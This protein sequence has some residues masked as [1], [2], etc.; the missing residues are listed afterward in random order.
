MARL[1]ICGLILTAACA[2]AADDTYTHVLPGARPG[3]VVTLTGLAGGSNPASV[4]T[5]GENGPLSNPTTIDVT[6][7]KTRTYNVT[8][9]DT[10]SVVIT[11]PRQTK[12]SMTCTEEVPYAW[13]LRISWPWCVSYLIQHLTTT[14]TER[15]SESASSRFALIPAQSRFNELH[16]STTD[17]TLLKLGG[18]TVTIPKNGRITLENIAASSAEFQTA[19]GATSTGYLT[20]RLKGP[21][22]GTAAVSM[23]EEF[24]AREFTIPH[25]YNDPSWQ[26]AFLA[27]NISGKDAVLYLTLMGDK[28]TELKTVRQ[29][30]PANGTYSAIPKALFGDT[31][32]GKWI[33]GRSD[34]PVSAI[35]LDAT[36]GQVIA[37]TATT[38]FDAG[39]RHLATNVKPGGWH[40]FESQSDY[41]ETIDMMGRDAEGK[42]VATATQTIAARDKLLI[43]ITKTLPGAATVEYN[44]QWSGDTTRNMGRVSGVAY[45]IA[46]GTITART[47]DCINDFQQLIELDNYNPRY[48]EYT[49]VVGDGKATVRATVRMNGMEEFLKATSVDEY[50]HYNLQYAWF[51]TKMNV[52]PA[53]TVK[54]TQQTS[55]GVTGDGGVINRKIEQRMVVTVTANTGQRY[56]EP[57][58]PLTLMPVI[59]YDVDGV[60][61]AGYSYNAVKNDPEGF[62]RIM[63]TPGAFTD[64][65]NYDA[66]LSWTKVVTDGTAGNDE[67]EKLFLGA[68]GNSKS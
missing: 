56:L 22:W 25:V 65:I 24:A 13:M 52:T 23:P 31:T 1:L 29:T 59:D 46:D 39:Y 30:L 35:T 57:G 28:R 34:Q 51:A 37:N 19:A 8:G 38:R 44:V 6:G 36:G 41:S 61:G 68:R 11:S 27:V 33:R 43:D 10:R 67:L 53:R 5:L 62:A 64:Q 15:S 40:I 58:T 60:N 48:G 49:G 55:T 45:G 2:A 50:S 18:T 14:Y 63:S 17:A 20:Q 3:C 9:A 21:L 66:A 47:I 54:A 12:A 7:R 42:Q 4:Q 32:N 16:V 26:G